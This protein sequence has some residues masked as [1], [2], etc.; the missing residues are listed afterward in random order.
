MNQPWP[1]IDPEGWAVQRR[2]NDAD[3]T[4]VLARFVTERRNTVAWLRDRVTSD[5]S[6]AYEY[7]QYGPIRAGDLLVAW[8]AHD[9]LHLRQIAKRLHQLAQRDAEGYS[10]I[11]AGE[12]RA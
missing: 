3:L 1:P 12:W 2:Y 7:P 6:T 11:Y 4:D 10:I 9:A 5:W 8:A